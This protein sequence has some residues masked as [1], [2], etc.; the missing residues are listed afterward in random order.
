MLQTLRTREQENP[1]KWTSSNR[2]E[3]RIQT[4]TY[5]S[6]TEHSSLYLIFW[7]KKKTSLT[8]GEHNGSFWPIFRLQPKVAFRYLKKKAGPRPYSCSSILKKKFFA[9]FLKYEKDFRGTFNIY[10]LLKECWK[11]SSAKYSKYRV[12][13]ILFSTS[14]IQVLQN[15]KHETLSLMFISHT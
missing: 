12:F 10:K 8:F 15:N 9:N 5:V 4:I 3:D 14:S 2:A 11:Q 1:R 7:I 13:E 6:S